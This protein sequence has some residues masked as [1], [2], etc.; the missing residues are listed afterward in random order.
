MLQNNPI[1]LN[2]LSSGPTEMTVQACITPQPGMGALPLR[3]WTAV[4]SSSHR[5]ATLSLLKQRGK[6]LIFLDLYTLWG[7]LSIFEKHL[8]SSPLFLYDNTF[9]QSMILLS[10]PGESQKS[11]VSLHFILSL[12]PLVQA[13]SVSADITHFY[14]LDSA[15]MS[16]FIYKSY[17]KTIKWVFSHTLGVL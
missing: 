15:E 17:L 12:L 5:V 3:S 10:H 11:I 4:L 14:F 13:G 7:I 16:L 8:G 9:S 6:Q 2:I 1:W